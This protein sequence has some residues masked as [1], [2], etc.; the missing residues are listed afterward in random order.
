MN[1]IARRDT[2][3]SII[4]ICIDQRRIDPKTGQELVFFPSGKTMMLPPNIHSVPA[5]LLP[6]SRYEVVLGN[7]IYKALGLPD[8][9]NPSSGG[10]GGGG[11]AEG[12]G[13]LAEAN[14]GEP[15]AFGFGGSGGIG[16]S[17]GVGGSSFASASYEFKPMGAMPEN[18][19]SNKIRD[20]GGSV[21]NHLMEQRRRQ[22]TDLG[23][24]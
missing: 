2:I 4:P 10:G 19:T 8:P 16:G 23:F 1:E 9:S 21:V 17:A 22:D 20:D 18:Y 11:A 5:L 15:Q 13:V 14:R 3:D 12:G 7:D 6:N 24:E